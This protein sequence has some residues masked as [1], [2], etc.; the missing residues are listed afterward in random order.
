MDIKFENKSKQISGVANYWLVWFIFIFVLMYMYKSKQPLW[1]IIP[2]A[3]CVPVGNP[4]KAILEVK[5]NARRKE[6]KTD[7]FTGSSLSELSTEY[8]DYR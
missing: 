2:A 7:M 8:S 5:E 3:V 6:E 1:L 4:I